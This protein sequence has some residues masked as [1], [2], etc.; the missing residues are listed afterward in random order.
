V[1]DAQRALD[2]DEFRAD[3]ANCFGLCCVAPGF[4]KSA[5]FAIDKPAGQACPNLQGDFRCGIHSRLRTQGFSG[6]TVYD[7]FGAGQQISQVTFGGRDW[8]AMPQS[9]PRMF[10]AFPIMRALHELLWYLTEALTLPAAQPVHASIRAVIEDLERL[11]Q[12]DPDT[13]LAV[14][15]AARR[16]EANPLLRQASELVRAQVTS[17]PAE[18]GGADLVGA[19][20]T[21]ADLRGANLRGAYLISADLREADARTADFTGAD[22]RAADL[23][24]ANLAGALFLVQAQLDAADGDARTALSPPLRHPAHWLPTTQPATR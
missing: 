3:C 14:D 4:A 16:Q 20:L 23:R 13:L 7:C 9:A 8:H 5:E 11:R 6:C 19:N 22:L 18:Y 17:R 2:P 10:E 12:S 24:G 1:A 15:V 21:G